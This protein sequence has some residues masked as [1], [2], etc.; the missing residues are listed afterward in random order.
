[1]SKENIEAI[2][3]LSPLQEGMF[4][5]SLYAPQSGVYFQQLSCVLE[6][7]LNHEAFA[8]A[9]Q[10]VVERHA[11]LR[12]AF[13]WKRLE[14][15]L[16]VVSKRVNV[17]I[18]TFDWGESTHD[19]QQQRLR[20]FLQEDKQL[21]FDLTKAPL[22]R[23]FLIRLSDDKHQFV[24]SHSNM[25]LDGWSLFLVVKEV[26]E[27]YDGFRKGKEPVLPV[28]PA[29][30]EYIDWIKEQDTGRAARF[31]SKTLSGFTKPNA[32]DIKTEASGDEE[33]YCEL[34]V[35]LSEALS[36]DLQAFSRK[37]KL[38]LNTLIQG[39]WA[40][41]LHL[42]TGDDD[43]VFGTTVSGRPP[44]LQKVESMVG[45]FINTLPVRVAIAPQQTVVPW[46]KE[47]Q[48]SNVELRD[49]EYSQLADVQ[50]N[51][52]VAPG[53]PLFNSIIVFESYPVDNAVN[54]MDT[55]LKIRG[56]SFVEQT[57]YALTFIAI[58][59][60]R[61]VLRIAFATRDFHPNAIRRMLAQ[62]QRILESMLAA[63]NQSLI[64]F[65]APS[66]QELQTIDSKLI[67]PTGQEYLDQCVHKLFEQQV[68]RT[69]ESVALVFEGE[70]FTY[71]QLNRRANQLAHYL[72][73]FGAGP[74]V[75]IGICID[76]SPD[77]IASVL[78][79]LKAGAA[80]L[81]LDPA[82]PSERLAYMVKD[83]GVSLLVTNESLA[84]RAQQDG[85]R[86]IKVDSDS[87]LI[88]RE[89][90]AN[91][92]CAISPDNLV[93]VI[94]TSGSTGTPKG[95][96]VTHRSLVNYVVSMVPVIGLEREQ[97]FL[98][99]ASLSFDASAVQIF[100]TL[101]SGATLVLHR[102]PAELSHFELKEFCEN[103]HLTVLD[104]PAGFWQQWIEDLSSQDTV[105]P[106]SIRFY[107][108]GG[109]SV[110]FDRVRKWAQMLEQPSQFLSSY[111]PTETTI[112]VMISITDS[113]SA[114]ESNRPNLPLGFAL[115]NT[116]IHLLDRYLRRVPEG[117][118]GEIYIGG[119]GLGRCYLGQ[120]GQTAEKFVPDGMS[121]AGGGRLYRTGDL[122]RVVNGE[123]EYVGRVDE[124]VKV[125][126]YRIELG[127][128]EA[129]LN[130]QAEVKASAVVENEGRLVAYVELRA[131]VAAAELQQ[132]LR[133]RL[134]E[135]MV[136]GVYERVA[137]LPVNRNGKVDRKRLREAAVERLAVGSE[138][139]A[140]R[141]G[142]EEV[143]AGI[144]SEVLQVERVGIHD[145]FFELGGHSLLATQLISRLRDVLKL[146]IPMKA[147]FATPT[148]AGLQHGHRTAT[149]CSPQPASRGNGTDTENG[150]GSRAFVRPTA[151]LDF[152]PARAG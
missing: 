19:K 78:G 112:G 135:W 136:P 151:S 65:V 54:Q 140:A 76:R 50:R 45:L 77:M 131:G 73:R 87:V 28:A 71:A 5:H 53:S 38:T 110:S 84:A 149:P 48:S 122:G 123:L 52:E 40:M 97:R 143:L 138:Y 57:N 60:T 69:P 1:M 148:V 58:P 64:S 104:I 46:L 33:S 145:D 130:G 92:C 127:E 107:M 117:V 42:Y 11:I 129:E 56:F 31:W 95:V 119:A 67:G 88:A 89:S 142:V 70:S 47:I 147:L 36:S 16:Q 39:A 41:L 66:G 43:I 141:S 75:R 49:Y 12:T 98:Q 115:P 21:G 15:P 133:K 124:Q 34:Q 32:V 105:L 18:E 125:R 82:Y 37:H 99:F 51:S 14:K 44:G 74:E 63:P 20:E 132:R 106:R 116:Q 152:G 61:M 100:P 120:P 7:Q 35:E 13:V 146:E 93:Y 101:L 134:P 24:W 6:G 128:I 121:G 126:G 4:F 81:P 8:R 114:S 62:V 86:V 144:W 26:F 108:T 55:G 80:Y 94:Y 59:G 30:K 29:F 111:G 150:I 103:E 113:E 118:A 22:M 10:R 72:R 109:E 137:Q 23:L 2:Y 96:M 102:A 139:E 68:E 25:L 9:W 91:S 83:A 27:F 79:I 3:E 17:A 85:M 90:E